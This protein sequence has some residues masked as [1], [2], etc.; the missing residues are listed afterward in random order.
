MFPDIM[1]WITWLYLWTW[2]IWPFVLVITFAQ[3]L[4]TYL[5]SEEDKIPFELYL[6]AFTLLVILSAVIAPQLGY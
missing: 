6:S 5:K 2:P 4:K 3:G 1:N